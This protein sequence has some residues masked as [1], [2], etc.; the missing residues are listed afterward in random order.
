MKNEKMMTAMMEA[1]DDGES[2]NV[3]LLTESNRQL[4]AA[5]LKHSEAQMAMVV[6]MQNQTLQAMERM[7]AQAAGRYMAL[8]DR[9]ALQS[10]SRYSPAPPSAG[11]AG[12]PAVSVEGGD[13]QT[14]DGAGFA[15]DDGFS[16]VPAETVLGGSAFPPMT[17]QWR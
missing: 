7:A 15:D 11:R 13:A 14:A 2:A 1:L 4:M 10:V 6:S 3:R 5:M 16:E 12:S 17:N 9:Q 8:T